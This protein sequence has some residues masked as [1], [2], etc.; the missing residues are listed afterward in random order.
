MKL[1][2][3]TNT[4][5]EGERVRATCEAFLSAGAD[6]VVVCA[7]GTTDGSCDD[8]PKGVVVIR[9]QKSKGCGQAKALATLAASG[10]VFL[11]VDS[12]QCVFDGDLRAL[13]GAAA[14]NGTVVCPAIGNIFYDESWTP[15]KM[16]NGGRLFFP[17]N[18]SILP[19]STA[20]YRGAPHERTVQ[21][22]VGLCMSRK[23]YLRCGGWSRFRGRHGSQERGM[24]LRAYMAGVDVEVDRSVLIG[25]EFFGKTHPSRNP[26]SGQYRFSN[27]APAVF[28]AWH[29]YMAV[30]GDAAFNNNV[31][32]WL[33]SLDGNMHAGDAVMED[34]MA[35]AD[36]DYFLRHCKRRTDDELL[37]LIE[38]LMAAR[39]PVRD[40]GGAA[41]EPAAV[42]IIKAMAHGRCLELGTGS[43]AGTQAL[44]EGAMSVVSVDHMPR[45]TKLAR[46]KIHNPNVE[47]VTCPIDK[48]TGFYDLS[49]IRGKFDLIVI[50]GP[51]GRKARESAISEVMR[52]CAAG[53]IILEDDAVRDG[54]NIKIAAEAA[55]CSVETFPTQRG[56]AMIQVVA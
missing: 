5:N 11:W 13:A 12:H 56:L 27:G 32:P 17:N 23:T 54:K 51:P 7:D 6:E 36:R 48:N 21:V 39:A 55:G 29:S 38:E 10:D 53:G 1:S 9:N 31:V 2:V 8:L 24:A 41:L 28:N 3:I 4:L 49:S 15:R 20:Q 40:S 42:R 47:F 35:I 25:H 33:L 34:A 44:L 52:L 30:C 37:V 22:G 43:G 16:E 45:F 50:D 14:E 19:H 26:E 18:D 46:A